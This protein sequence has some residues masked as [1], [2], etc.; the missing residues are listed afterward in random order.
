MINMTYIQTVSLSPN[1]I[2]A[3]T[4]IEAI[5]DKCVKEGVTYKVYEDTLSISIKWG[6]NKIT[7]INSFIDDTR[8]E[9]Y[10]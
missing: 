2:E 7:V 8:K 4:I 9:E 6:M 10:K 5:K 1:N 3:Q